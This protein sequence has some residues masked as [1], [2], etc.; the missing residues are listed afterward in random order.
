MRLDIGRLQQ[1]EQSDAVDRA[2]SAGDPNDQS[3]RM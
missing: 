1:A 3:S 2:G